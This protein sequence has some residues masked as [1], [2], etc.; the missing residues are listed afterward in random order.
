MIVVV[1]RLLLPGTGASTTFFDFFRMPFSGSSSRC[2]SYSTV[3]D[4][5]NETTKFFTHIS[6]SFVPYGLFVYL[7][8]T[9]NKWN[10]EVFCI[11]QR[12][13]LVSRRAS[14]MTTAP[15]P[16]RR[17]IAAPRTAR[18]ATNSAARLKRCTLLGAQKGSFVP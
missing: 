9:T 18:R 14:R 3:C 6:R 15:T 2:V 16:H 12:L 10:D 7:T 13:F 11:A 17:R 4:G 1:E 5:I 8:T